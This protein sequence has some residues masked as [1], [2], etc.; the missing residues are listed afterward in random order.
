MLNT[1]LASNVYADVIREQNRE[2]ATL[3]LR[4]QQETEDRGGSFD[5]LR[6]LEARISADEIA[7]LSAAFIEKAE[8]VDLLNPGGIPLLQVLDA[9]QAHYGI[10]TYGHEQWQTVKLQASKL[11]NIPYFI[12]PEKH[13]GRL[14]QAWQ[15]EDGRFLIPT[16]LLYPHD[17]L[18]LD[19]NGHVV[20]SATLLGELALFDTITQTDDKAV[21]F[22]GIPE[23]VDGYWYQKTDTLLPSQTGKVPQRVRVVRH[24]AQVAENE[25]GD[26]IIAA[27]G[28]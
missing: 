22:E 21:S 12:T 11:D 7:A 4:D 19:E 13:K 10:L 20:D 15:Q 24:L 2:L 9:Q 16:E 14:M 23:Q 25:F 28:V 1:P 17:A 8:H 3:M 6:F 27:A 26:H 5:L 18:P